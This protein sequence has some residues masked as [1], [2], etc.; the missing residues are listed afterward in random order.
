[1]HPDRPHVRARA[2]A[3]TV[4]TSAALVLL[5]VLG[6]LGTGPATAGAQSSDAGAYLSRINSLRASVGAPPLQADATLDGLARGWAQHLADQGALSH[7]GDLSSGLRGPWAK[8]GENV[9]MGPDTGT[10]FN[11]FVNSPGHYAN[12]VD[13]AFTHI[14]IGVVWAGAVQYT[15]HRFLAAAGP[16]SGGTGGDGTGGDGTGG[17][18]TGGVAPVPDLPGPGTGGEDDTRLRA[19]DAERPPGDTAPDGPSG[20]A[21]APVPPPPASAD[22]VGA[23]VAA[24][25]AIPS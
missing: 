23:T 21:A 12:L 18:G 16:T 5:T 7:A 11:A 2:G 14:G 9:G 1:M 25:R 13:P 6:A 10:I 15:A 19:G 20:E 3:R 24:L 8:L 17:S 4:A 22:R